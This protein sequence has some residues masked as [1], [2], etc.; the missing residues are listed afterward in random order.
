MVSLWWI[1]LHS[2]WLFWS[3]SFQYGAQQKHV[4]VVLENVAWRWASS[5]VSSSPWGFTPRWMVF[6]SGKSHRSK[7]MMMTIGVPPLME[8]PILGHH[9]MLLF[10]GVMDVNSAKGRMGCKISK[11]G[12][13][14]HFSGISSAVWSENTWEVNIILFEVVKT[15]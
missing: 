2:V 8:T 12:W 5:E 13:P 11:K 1:E 9:H 3:N 10:G 14:S 6:C 4:M 15:G 7:W